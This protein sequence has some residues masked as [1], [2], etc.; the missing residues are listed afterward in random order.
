MSTPRKPPK[1]TTTRSDVISPKKTP[2]QSKNNDRKTFEEQP[3]RHTKKGNR[4]V[5][6]NAMTK[7]EKKNMAAVSFEPKL[8]TITDSYDTTIPLTLEMLAINLNWQITMLQRSLVSDIASIIRE[9]SP[10]L[11][12]FVVFLFCFYVLCFFCKT[13]LFVQKEICRC[14]SMEHTHTH[15]HTHTIKCKNKL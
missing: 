15:T 9:Y 12:F 7:A 4:S 8:N 6:L 13:Q 5:S 1:I 3:P 2:K 10:V 11:F 14:T